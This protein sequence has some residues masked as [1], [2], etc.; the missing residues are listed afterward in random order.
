M[1]H[2]CIPLSDMT[3]KDRESVFVYTTQYHN[4]M[5]LTRLSQPVSHLVSITLEVAFKCIPTMYL[6]ILTIVLCKLKTIVE[7]MQATMCYAQ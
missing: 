2:E 4:E 6:K 5:L 7:T 3:L 1:G